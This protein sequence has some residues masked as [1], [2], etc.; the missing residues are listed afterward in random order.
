MYAPN[1]CSLSNEKLFSLTYLATDKIAGK[2]L[3]QNSVR[4]CK[5][6]QQ[7]HFQLFP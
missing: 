2:F 4:W 5:L 1:I 3:T 6:W 7:I